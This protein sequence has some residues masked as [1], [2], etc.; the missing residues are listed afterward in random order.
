MPPVQR[1]APIHAGARQQ[2]LDHLENCKASIDVLMG[3]QVDNGTV[4]ALTH[5]VNAVLLF[6]DTHTEHIP[7]DALFE[8]HESVLADLSQASAESRSWQPT[9]QDWRAARRAHGVCNRI[10]RYLRETGRES[11][12]RRGKRGRPLDAE[13]DP[14]KDK[15]L[16]QQWRDARA[17]GNTRKAF[18]SHLGIS[19]QDL[20]AAQDRERYRRR[21]DAE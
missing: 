7:A 20:I 3:G 21:R 18:T 19:V 12:K 17:A 4:D 11:G 10:I 5:S 6:R 13:I 16:C 8:F 14:K 2:A 15:Q 1:S 9:D